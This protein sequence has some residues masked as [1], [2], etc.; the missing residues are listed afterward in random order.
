VWAFEEPVAP[1]YPVAAGPAADHDD[2]VARFGFL[3]DDRRDGGGGDDGTELHAF[4][5]EAGVVILDDLSGRE[6]YLVAVGAEAGGGLAGQ[7]D[8][9]ELAGDRRTGGSA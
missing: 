3:A 5:E 1:P 6:P 4:G 7:L 8:L 9:R 2:D